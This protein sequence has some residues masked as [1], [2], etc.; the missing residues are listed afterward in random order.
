MA[1]PRDLWT[2]SETRRL[3]ME[4][5]ATTRR[6]AELKV[7]SEQRRVDREETRTRARMRR[8]AERPHAD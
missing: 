5:A 1:G 7:E 6:S 8:N 3:R 4:A 2:L